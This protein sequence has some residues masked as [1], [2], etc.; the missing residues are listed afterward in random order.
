MNRKLLEGIFNAAML[1]AKTMKKPKRGGYRPNAGRIA[2]D[3]AENLR[4]IN[5]MLDDTTIEKAKEIGNSNLS[6]GIRR[7]V[8][9]RKGSK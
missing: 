9:S 3:G 4:R 8:K 6:L 5:V 2:N 1:H 7:A